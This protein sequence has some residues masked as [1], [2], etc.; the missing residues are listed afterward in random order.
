MSIF[1][2]IGN[3]LSGGVGS[4][5]G[6]VVSAA[7]SLFGGQQTN[8]SNQQI[9][10]DS[11][12]ANA[13]QAQ[14]N[15]DFQERMS[16]TAYTR[17]VGD[18]NTAGLNPMLAYSQGGASSPGGNTIP[19]V[20]IPNQ[21]YAGAAIQQGLQYA[22]NTAQIANV[23]ADTLAKLAQLP[24]KQVGGDI[25]GAMRK[26]LTPALP[27]SSAA[28]AHDRISS[29]DLPSPSSA[30]SGDDWLTEL[31]RNPTVDS[32][33]PLHKAVDAVGEWNPYGF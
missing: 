15:R 25:W 22:T 21:N 30:S 2:S 19:Q 32:R 23:N 28:S 10:G 12:V 16:D 17:A 20:Q 24:E 33:S 7:G 6:G 27:T 18:L 5:I 13:E 31:T 8:A 11:N 26:L 9:A 3:F 4:L 1:S 14:L 29:D